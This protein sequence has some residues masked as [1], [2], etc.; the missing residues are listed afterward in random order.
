[1]YLIALS[2]L[3]GQRTQHVPA[4]IPTPIAHPVASMMSSIHVVANALYGLFLER[5]SLARAP[6]AS[7]TLLS[8]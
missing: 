5:P 8:A 4:M 3:V 2:A 7:C 1:L 6:P